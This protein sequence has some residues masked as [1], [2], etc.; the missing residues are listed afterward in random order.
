MRFIR[1]ILAATA[2]NFT[3]V[4]D[5]AQPGTNTGRTRRLEP[6]RNRRHRLTLGI[7]LSCSILA[8]SALAIPNSNIA[9][10]IRNWHRT[11]A[12]QEVALSK[13]DYSRFR[14]IARATATEQG[15]G[16]RLLLSFAAPVLVL[17]APTSLGVSTVS[18]T[19]ISLS[20]T[21]P[22]GTVNHYQIERSTSLSGPFT[23]IG[24]S[25]TT[26]FDNTGLSGVHSY[27]YRVRAVDSFGAQSAPSNMALGT[28]IAF[29]DPTL[30]ASVTQVRAQHIYDLR[31]A[32]DAVRAVVPSLST[33]SWTPYPLEQVVI[34]ATDVQDLRDKLGDA[35]AALSISPGAYE[36]S[37]LAT[38]TNGT[39]IKKIHIEQLRERSTKGSSTSSG[40]ADNSYSDSSTAR[41]D[42]LNRTGS[43]GE[44]PL[45][46]NFNWSIPLVGL[47]GR[48]GLDLGLSMAYNSL[49]TWIRNGNVISFDDDHGSPAPG[50]RLGF[51]VIQQFF[52][53]A[54]GSKSF[55]MITPTGVRVELRQVGTSNL[56]QA[57]DSSYLLLDSTTMTLRTTGG[58]QLSYVWKNG[59]YECALIK[60][61]NGNYLTINYD[62]VDRIDTIVDTLPMASVQLH[63][64]GRDRRTT[65]PALPTPVSPSR[66]TSRG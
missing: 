64:P 8:G 59:N 46:R 22:S 54:Q 40:P 32:I 31:Q 4:R 23:T 63:R 18:S 58:T 26:S 61:S 19:Q 12:P 25:A 13:R 34:H 20:W 60:D 27:L 52:N 11:E 28:S 3:S 56:Y 2:K 42:P 14:S 53:N 7:A 35:L 47:P 43:G 1:S 57:V 17:D 45:S 37:T 51:P 21:A 55:L 9:T 30:Y 29:T 50:F 33:V 10:W 15:F 16:T 49:A 48:S 6:A 5:S 38:G 65:G 62:I 36:D 39:L 44:D 24:T 41:L 66:Q